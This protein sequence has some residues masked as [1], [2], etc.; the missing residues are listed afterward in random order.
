MVW[1][2]R[3]RRLLPASR[4]ASALR[5]LIKGIPIES[6]TDA[7]DCYPELDPIVRGM[8]QILLGSQIPL[9]RLHRRVAQQQLDL[10]KLAAGCAAQLGAVRRKSCA[11][12]IAKTFSEI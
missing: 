10:F 3:C 1:K 4:P 9:G 6:L 11:S 2:L 8:Y 12:C 5:R 7:L